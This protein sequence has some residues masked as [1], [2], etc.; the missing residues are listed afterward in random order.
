MRQVWVT[1]AGPPDVLQVRE[2][3][4]P[5]PAPGEVRI[6][7]EAVGVNFA[8]IMGRLGLYPDAPRIPFVPG[9]E[10]AGRIDAL[11]AGVDPARAGQ[12]VLA[13]VRYGGYSEKVCAPADQVLP[14]PATLAVEEAAAFPVAYLAAY[15]GLVA[16]AGIK[17]GE[18][19]LIQA[20]AGGLGLAAVNLA[21]LFDATIY[22]TASASKH[23][24]LRAQG[25]HHPID[26][27][28]LDFEREVR[29]L[30]DGRGVQIALDSIGGRSWLKSYRALAPM[31]RLVIIGVSAM[32]PGLRRS[33]WGLLRFAL[34][35]PWLRFNPVALANDNKGVLGVNLGRLWDA[36]AMLAPW[37]A[38][39]LAWH[40][41]GR[42]SVH[43]DR[44]FALADAAE[45][46]R[47]LQ[48]RQ[49]TGKVILKP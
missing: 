3:P 14:R 13:L 47:Y 35:V 34:G 17:P 25:V 11:G 41:E 21:R 40:A 15:A 10:V 36:R 30:T 2:V 8:D 38:Q 49:N 31:G 20:A 46:H 42:L 23:D 5:Q 7:V 6:A 45:A 18:S 4:E 39:L 19:V 22:G 29:R 37:M 1:K 12:D 26:Y 16:L 44:A 43:V 28:R 9:L 32:A 48:G 33:P 24:F 27:R